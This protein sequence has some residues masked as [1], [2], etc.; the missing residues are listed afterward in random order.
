MS[1]IVEDIVLKK[2]KSN[3]EVLGSSMDNISDKTDLLKSGILDSME[4]IE[5]L[6]EISD[7]TGITLDFLLNDEEELIISIDWFLKRF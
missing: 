7:I 2:I 4:F 5:I 6:T 3:L 1:Q